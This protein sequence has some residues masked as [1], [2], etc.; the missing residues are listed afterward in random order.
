VGDKKL[1]NSFY[2]HKK[3]VAKAAN[4]KRLAEDEESVNEASRAV[5]MDANEKE[6]IEKFFEENRIE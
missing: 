4:K 5:S 2:H 3:R 6:E 1:I